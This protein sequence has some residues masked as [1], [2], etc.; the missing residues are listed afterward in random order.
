M[1][2]APTMLP[3]TIWHVL[4]LSNQMLESTYMPHTAMMKV[5][6][7]RLRTNGAKIME[8]ANRQC[9]MVHAVSRLGL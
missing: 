4:M 2:M 7:L 6:L 5:Q 1:Q 8:L 9:D 3:P